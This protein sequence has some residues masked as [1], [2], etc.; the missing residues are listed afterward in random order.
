MKKLTLFL[1]LLAATFLHAQTPPA[2]VN[3]LASGCF[4]DSSGAPLRNGELQ[5]V[6]SSAFRIGG[7]GQSS[8]DKVVRTITNGSMD[9][10]LQ[11]A[12]RGATSPLN[13]SYIV[14]VFNARA[15]HSDTYKNVVVTPDGSGNFDWCQ[16]NTGLSV[17]GT[18]IVQVVGPAG[19]AASIAVGTIT[20]LA[21]DQPA[22]V[23]NRG[24]SS[25]AIFD[26]GIPRGEPGNGSDEGT[27]GPQGMSAYQVAVANGFV[28]TE[29]Q[30]L[31][32]LIGQQ[33]IQGIQGPPGTNGTNGTN[34]SNGAAATIAVHNV[35]TLSPGSQATV[36]NSGTTSAAQLDFGIPQGIAGT[37]GST[38]YSGAG[39]PSSSTGV[40]GDFYINTTSYDYSKKTGASTWTVQ[41]NLKGPAGPAGSVPTNTQTA[42]TGGVSQY[43]FVEKD[44]SSPTLFVTASSGSCGSGVALGSAIAGGTFALSEAY[45]TVLVTVDSAGITAGHLVVGSTTTPGL[46]MDSGQ[47]ATSAIPYNTP[48]CGTALNTVAGGATVTLLPRS[49]GS[50]GAKISPMVASGALHAAGFV[51]DPGITAGSTRYLRE[52]GTWALPSSSSS[53]GYTMSFSGALYSAVAST[54]RYLGLA[55]WESTSSSPSAAYAT[56]PQTGHVKEIEFTLDTAGGSSLGGTVGVVLY[57][58]TTS[59]ALTTFSLADPG[60]GI[61]V[62]TDQTLNVAV[63]KGDKLQWQLTPAVGTASRNVTPRGSVYVEQ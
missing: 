5:I 4:K 14:T 61:S 8:T 30:W 44:T 16:Y 24:S 23:T 54:T 11:L 2:M 46:A 9:G 31:A 58:L 1:L 52:D 15:N 41:G 17:P 47:T 7:G 34:G 29:V 50:F 45:G 26:F 19:T 37:N 51:P 38:W 20:T 43:T 57:D 12:N 42:G 59:T 63:T 13:I 53:L 35:S 33:G 55:A 28:G 21:P 3:F 56:V 6:P 36:A 60:S 27:Q 40:V 62:W 25:A 10:T 39:A 18:P 32:S 48:I 49:R 22:T